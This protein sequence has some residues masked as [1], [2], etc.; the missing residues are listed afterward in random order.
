MSYLGESH[1][2]YIDLG[3]EDEGRRQVCKVG[4]P[5]GRG[6]GLRYILTLHRKAP[7]GDI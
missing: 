3:C 2:Q 7:A 4:E 5:R 6:V 1:P